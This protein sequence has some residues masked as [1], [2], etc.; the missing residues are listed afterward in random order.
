VWC[1]PAAPISVRLCVCVREEGRREGGRK[2]G[3]EGCWC[4]GL[5]LCMEELCRCACTTTL[6]RESSRSQPRD[7][8]GLTDGGGNGGQTEGKGLR[9]ISPRRPPNLEIEAE[10]CTG[11]LAI[12]PAAACLVLLA[13]CCTHL[14]CLPPA[15]EA[16]AAATWWQWS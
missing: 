10:Q 5:V 1:E 12:G 3:R 7:T 2:G 11:C 14:F 15:A 16:T 13:S 4:A 6:T 9:H 8:H